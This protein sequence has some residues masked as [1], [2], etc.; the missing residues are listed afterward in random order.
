[1]Q[2]TLD[3]HYDKL[4]IGAD[5]SALSFAYINKIPI[6]YLRKLYPYKYNI[7]YDYEKELKLYQDLLFILS[8]TKYVPFGELVESIRIEDDN[9]L[10]VITKGVFSINV[11]FNKLIISDDYKISGLPPP[12]SKTNTKNYVL[13]WFEAN[14]GCVH[15]LE[16]ITS[17]DEFVKKTFFYIS[18]RMMFNNIKKDC[19]STSIIDD[20]DLDFFEFSQTSAGFKTAKMMKDAGIR[21]KWDKTNDKFK[22]IKL[23]SI[24]REV[25]PLGKNIYEETPATISFL[26]QNHEDILKQDKKQDKTINLIEEKY[27]I[28]R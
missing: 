7:N 11:T 3:L 20:K 18:D 22:S 8:I 25:Y 27:G 15:A 19:V 6:I 21:G 14:R 26:Y 4:I 24:K 5:L 23:T 28:F 9:K 10:K 16:D 17:N 12:T 13:D 1:M 2:R